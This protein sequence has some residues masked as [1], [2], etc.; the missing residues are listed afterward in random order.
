[1]SVT[2]VRKSQV[3]PNLVLQGFE[4]T[5]EALDDYYHMFPG[6]SEEHLDGLLRK[7]V[8][9]KVKGGT[10][11]VGEAL[12]QVNK[13]RVFGIGFL[14]GMGAKP[15]PLSCPVCGGRGS[16]VFYDE[17]PLCHG[18]GCPSCSDGMVK[19]EKPCTHG[20]CIVKARGKGNA[21]KKTQRKHHFQQRH[22]RR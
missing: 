18:S 12:F 2:I 10:H 22:R 19:V 6:G 5:P 17:C 16:L 21:R 4:I 7:M 20:T 15:G 1:M 3:Q 11:A 14:A 13:A 9:V 8:K